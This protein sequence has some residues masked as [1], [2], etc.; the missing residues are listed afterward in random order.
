MTEVKDIKTSLSIDEKNKD[1]RTRSNEQKIGS[2]DN[3]MTSN[4]K[5]ETPGKKAEKR[6]KK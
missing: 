4:K 6:S 5:I 2:R 1:S 3:R